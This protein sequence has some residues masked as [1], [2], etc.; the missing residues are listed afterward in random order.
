MSPLAIVL[1]VLSYFALL[2][3][4]A[5]ITARG[6]TELSYTLGDRRSPWWL[7]AFGAIGDAL[8]GVTFISVPGEVGKRHFAYLQ[9]VFGYVVG[10]AII[11]QVLL[12][13]YY[14]LNLTS[15]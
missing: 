4:V 15:I 2:L 14:R 9:V 7:L 10:Y 13:L 8:S 3:G 1:G 11:A 5:W 12:P 6:A